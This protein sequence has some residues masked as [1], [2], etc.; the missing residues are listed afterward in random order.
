MSQADHCQYAR[1]SG[2][3]DAAGSRSH[4]RTGGRGHT[5][6]E[7]SGAG[8]Q[9]PRDRDCRLCLTLNAALSRQGFRHG[10][11][12]RQGSSY[13]NT[14]P[15]TKA[16]KIITAAKSN[17]ATAPRQY[18]SELLSKLCLWRRTQRHHKVQANIDAAAPRLHRLS[19][20]Q[21]G[22]L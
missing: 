5:W 10:S 2:W 13:L 4:R 19:A 3:A 14:P 18:R 20:A 11:I 22:L 8:A 15:I 6:H 9:A 21:L 1:Y 12:E 16:K 17:P 7:H